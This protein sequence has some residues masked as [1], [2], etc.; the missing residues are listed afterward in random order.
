MGN[1]EQ[2]YSWAIRNCRIRMFSLCCVSR[3]ICE[4]M[5]SSVCCCCIGTTHITIH[6]QFVHSINSSTQRWTNFS[7]HVLFWFS[8]RS[9]KLLTAYWKMWPSSRWSFYLS[10]LLIRF[11]FVCVCGTIRCLSTFDISRNTSLSFIP[12]H[13]Y[14]VSDKK[15]V[16]TAARCALRIGNMCVEIHFCSDF[17]S[18][19]V[20]PWICIEVTTQE[21]EPQ[22][23]KYDCV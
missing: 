6:V 19:Y 23:Q 17:T 3:C 1:K 13:L 22:A 4:S 14:S 5:N 11:A 12:F 2:Q 18:L 10:F 8:I 7:L 9:R 21:A 20:I 16:T 15:Q